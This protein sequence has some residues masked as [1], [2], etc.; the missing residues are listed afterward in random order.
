MAGAC[1]THNQSGSHA[2]QSSRSIVDHHTLHVYHVCSRTGATETSVLRNDLL[3]S[4]KWNVDSLNYIFRFNSTHKSRQAINFL[5]LFALYCNARV[6]KAATR[7]S[8]RGK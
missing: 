2:T 6:Q 4:D 3:L 1:E 5:T 8:I 7:Q